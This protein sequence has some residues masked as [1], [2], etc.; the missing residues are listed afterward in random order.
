M[1]HFILILLGN[2]VRVLSILIN[3]NDLDF[4][5]IILELSNLILIIKFG[6]NFVKTF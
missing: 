3:D 2:I 4:L 6:G 5:H 1:T